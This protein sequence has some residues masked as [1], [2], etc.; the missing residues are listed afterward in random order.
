MA[1]FNRYI[2]IDYS[3]AETADSSLPGLR[4]YEAD[5]ELDPKEVAHRYDPPIHP[6]KY[7]SRR[8]ITDWIIHQLNSGPAAII[9]IDHAFSFPLSF[10]NKYKLPHDW[11]TFLDYFQKNCP[12]DVEDGSVDF[13]RE[14]MTGSWRNIQGER[15]WFRLTEKWTA[16]ANSVF[17]FDVQGSVAKST[18]SGLPWLR[19]I[20]QECSKVVHFWPFDGWDVAEGR[21]VIVEVYPSLWMRRIPQDGRTNDQHSAYAVATWLRRAD[22]IDSL[23][24]YFSPPL[25]PEEAKAAEV[26]GWILGVDKKIRDEKLGEALASPFKTLPPFLRGRLFFLLD[27]HLEARGHFAV[28]LDR[29][30]ELAERLERL[31]E[32][33]LAAVDGEALGLE[34]LGHVT[35][36]DRAEEVVVLAHLAGELERDAGDLA[37]Q[38]LRLAFLLGGAAHGRSLHLLDHV[39]V[40]LGGLDGQTAGQQEIASVAVCDLHHVAAM[41]QFLDVFFQDDFHCCDSNLR[42]RSPLTGH[43]QKV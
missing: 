20:R 34:R 32:L 8:E 14:G 13:V 29:H 30:V 41:A 23:P 36:G 37:G 6:R 16:G 3:G 40:A 39:L 5:R 38:D 42:M 33:D 11:Q 2:G 19:R 7:W 15:D 12:L 1:H 21:S 28:Q 25:S 27:R 17:Q 4:I 26:E 24:R 35:G 43:L 10:F 18:Y 22:Q 9:G 31:V